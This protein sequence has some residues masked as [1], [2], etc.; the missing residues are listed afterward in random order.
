M[1]SRWVAGLAVAA[2]GIS[3][4][5]LD[6]QSVHASPPPQPTTY[7]VGWA[8]PGTSY[9]AASVSDVG[10]FGHPGYKKPYAWG[11]Q[12]GS[13]TRIC[14]QAWGFDAAHTKGTWF[15]SGCGK[16]GTALI[17]WGNVLGVPKM[18]ARSMTFLGG[19]FSWSI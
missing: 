4:G 6:A 8:P 13:N 1:K 19:V 7:Y 9:G 15:D 11:V 5:S 18:R 14:T 2:L 10:T 12:P 16:S 3:V 17:P